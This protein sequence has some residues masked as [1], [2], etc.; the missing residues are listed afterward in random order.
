MSSNNDSTLK[1]R[2]FIERGSA[3]A[4]GLFVTGASA[5]H[6]A[7]IKA[8][9]IAKTA[10]QAASPIG[11]A[12]IGLGD[13]GR[14]LLAALAI[15]PG[16]NILYVCD[17]YAPAHK[18]A[19]EIAPKA[20]AVED[21][22]KVL[23]DKAVQAIWVATPSHQHKDIVLAGLQAGKHVY[24]EAPLASSIEDAQAIAK[25]ANAAKGQ[26]FHAGLQQR[27]EPQHLHVLEFVRTGALATVAQIR[28][29]WHK[30]T[31]WRR[32]APT[33]DRQRALNWRLAKATSGGLMG[34][35]GIHQ[36]D[37]ANWFLKKTPTAVAGFGGIMAWK[38]GREVADTVQCVF[39]YEN[40]VHLS[41]DATLANSFDGAYELFQGTDAAI[42]LRGGR[43]W[44]VKETDA[45]ALGWEVY[46]Y[47]EKVGDDQTGIALV[48]DASKL[49]AQ[50]LKPG[51][52]REIDPTRTALYCSSDAFLNAIRENKKTTSGPAEGL[53]ATVSALKANEAVQTGSKITFQKEWFDLG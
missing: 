36:V 19:L 32:T 14:Q 8:P 25:A 4:L 33:D 31:S 3:L 30:K 10:G 34:E 17:T 12:V 41:Y 29:Q 45:P 44:M 46:A 13:Q 7:E 15:I 37:V 23:D 50:G 16:A 22:R 26:L 21:Y 53:A 40:G 43:G 9:A 5:L 49:L 2:D 11:C 52:H 42:F 39:E 51:E 20:T 24:C 48:A 35:I 6:A 38:D 18:R 28:S 47:K 27:T 1:R